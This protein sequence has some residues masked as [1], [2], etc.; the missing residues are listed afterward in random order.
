MICGKGHN[1]CVSVTKRVW[2]LR[3]PL[4]HRQTRYELVLRQ[5]RGWKN[6]GHFRLFLS[7]YSCRE[8]DYR[9]DGQ[10]MGPPGTTEAVHVL[11]SVV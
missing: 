11:K 2:K 8:Q 1:Y 4:S 10:P 9:C 6:L 5:T 7:N 3:N